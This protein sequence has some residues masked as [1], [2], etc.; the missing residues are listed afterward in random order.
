MRTEQ[1]ILENLIFSDE[2]ASLIGVFLKSE[3]FKAYPEKI[4]F[5]ENKIDKVCHLA[6]QA[7][8]RYSLENPFAYERSNNIGTL[9]IL[10]LM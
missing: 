5:T 9:N 4:V 1:L 6:A 7:G 3:Y 8:V 10:E 2:Y